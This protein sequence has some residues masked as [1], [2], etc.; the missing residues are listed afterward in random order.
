MTDF[1]LYF[2][3]LY[4]SWH[5]LV[6]LTCEVKEFRELGLTFCLTTYVPDQIRIHNTMKNRLSRIDSTVQGRNTMRNGDRG[7]TLPCHLQ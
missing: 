6:K 5:L 1:S 7:S 2:I 4:Y 3:P